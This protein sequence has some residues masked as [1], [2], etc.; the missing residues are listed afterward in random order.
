MFIKLEIINETKKAYQI[1]NGSWIPKSVLDGWGLIHPYYKVK[2]WWVKSTMDKFF[3]LRDKICEEQLKGLS[4]IEI[5]KSQMPN[6]VLQ[7]WLNYHDDSGFYGYDSTDRRW[8]LDP[9]Y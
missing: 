3:N 2:D 1:L 8:E 7:K 4:Q 6:N 5:Q 9:H